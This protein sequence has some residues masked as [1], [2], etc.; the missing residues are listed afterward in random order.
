MHVVGYHCPSLRT[1]SSN[2]VCV[3]V[4]N[5]TSSCRGTPRF[6]LQISWPRSFGSLAGGRKRLLNHAEADGVKNRI[7]REQSAWTHALQQ[8]SELH[9]ECEEA[10]AKRFVTWCS[11]W[12]SGCAAATSCTALPQ[13]LVQPSL[14]AAR[15]VTK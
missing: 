8:H 6:H 10:A 9:S 15:R 5:T 7:F 4:R 13:A 14:G 2:V 11:S 1:R 12:S 3:T